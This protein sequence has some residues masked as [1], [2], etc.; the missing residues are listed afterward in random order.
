MDPKKERNTTVVEDQMSIRPRTHYMP[1]ETQEEKLPEETPEEMPEQSLLLDIEEKGIFECSV[2]FSRF[3]L[4]TEL[5]QH[6]I[7]C[8]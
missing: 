2:C 1:E 4:L 8:R 7:E 6:K 3:G 5:R